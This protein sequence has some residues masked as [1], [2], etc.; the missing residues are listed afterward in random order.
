MKAKNTLWKRISVA[1]VLSVAATF[2]FL[3]SC[4][5]ENIQPLQDNAIKSSAAEPESELFPLTEICGEIQQKALLIGDRTK[6][7]DVYIFNDTKYLYVHVSALRFFELKNVYLYTG[8]RVDIPLTIAGDLAY[9]RFNHVLLSD[10]F[11]NT[12]RF[13]IPLS[14]LNGRFVVSLRADVKRDIG[15]SSL[16]RLSEA[17]A[18]GKPFGITT[19][20]RIFSYETTICL[21]NDPASLDE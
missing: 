7:G 17:W 5:K 8:P 2:G 18:D 6:A 3:I 15:N 19:F 12:K 20:G 14:E 4:E 11:S 1:L 16:V 10:V 13:K 9:K 21:I